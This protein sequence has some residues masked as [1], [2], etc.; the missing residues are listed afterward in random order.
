MK[1]FE[2]KYIILKYNY[3][4]FHGSSYNI[5]INIHNI[6]EMQMNDVKIAS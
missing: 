4:Y 6:N 5:F 2:I 3:S 1:L